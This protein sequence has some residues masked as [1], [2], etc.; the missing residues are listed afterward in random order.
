MKKKKKKQAR[1][2][3]L[4]N[5][6]QWRG[7]QDFGA[8]GSMMPYA[9]TAYNP[10]W[11]AAQHSGDGYMASGGSLVPFM[12]YGPGP[13]DP[14]F[15]AMMPSDMYAAQGYMQGFVPPIHR[16]YV[17]YGMNT[18]K[19]VMRREE[20]EATKA[21]LRK[22]REQEQRHN[23]RDHARDMSANGGDVVLPKHKVS[24]SSQATVTCAREDRGLSTECHKKSKQLQSL[25]P[26]SKRK[27]DREDFQMKEGRY[28]TD[29]KLDSQVNSDVEMNKAFKSGFARR[30]DKSQ[31]PVF[32]HR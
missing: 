1:Q 7:A 10:F 24:T 25:R 29:G 13:C 9:P 6:T 17:D 2:P 14:S 31:R 12:G 28:T 22:K 3:P 30:A 27:A 21:D 8:E 4:S 16:D 20:F 5:G 11:P 19:H 23:S 15:G 18:S 32:F 26:Q